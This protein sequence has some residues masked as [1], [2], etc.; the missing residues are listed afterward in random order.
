M[1][2]TA[3]SVDFTKYMLFS[4]V[5]IKHIYIYI[6]IYIHNKLAKK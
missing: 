2:N 5:Y 3:N 4:K 1:F 6:Y